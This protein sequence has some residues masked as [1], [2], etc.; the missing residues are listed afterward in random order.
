MIRLYHGSNIDVETP[1]LINQSRGLDFGS[2]FYLTTSEAQAMRFAEIVVKRRKKGVATVSIYD[3]DIETAN[4][5]L[6]I[7]AFTEANIEWLKFVVANRLKTYKGDEYD[8]V[9]GAVVS[10]TVMPTIQ[11]LLGG[12]LSEDAAIL[13]LRT[14]KLVDQVCL[15]SEKALILLNYIKSYEVRNTVDG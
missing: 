14:T 3:F 9:I 6:L 1:I 11:A 7:Q 4:K 8:I 12:F 5:T 2:G 13:T 15:K 10:D